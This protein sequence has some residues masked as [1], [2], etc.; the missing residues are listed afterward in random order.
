MAVKI[1]GYNDIAKVKDITTLNLLK[2]NFDRDYNKQ[3]ERLE[4]IEYAKSMQSKSFG[5][6]KE[7]FE[8]MSS[9]LFKS[10]EGRGILNKYI[11]CVKENA[12]LKK[13]HLL[14]E[15]VRKADKNIDV[16]NY[17]NEAKSMIGTVDQKSYPA[18]T[19]VLGTILGEACTKL[20]KEKSTAI[21]ES[22]N[23]DEKIDSAIE[24]VGTHNKTPKTLYMFAESYNS[25]R[26]IVNERDNSKKNGTSTLKESDI[27]RSINEFNEK[28]GKELDETGQQ[29]VRELSES[30]DKEAIFERYK[31]DCVNKLNEKR[32][33]FK[34]QGDNTTTERLEIVLEKLSKRKYNPETV[35]ADVFNFIEMV[36]SL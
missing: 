8:N 28:Y 5:Y 3:R 30:K 9:E 32:E 12:D 34:T 16:N 7:A 27:E 25:I 1:V 22:M 18:A 23:F 20:G 6:I 29:L 36:N 31:T 33:Q 24:Y 19:R 14:Y 26:E 35:N 21:M 11:A 15:C 2:E 10:K 4:T 13:M 17:L